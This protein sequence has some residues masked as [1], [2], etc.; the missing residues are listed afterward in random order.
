[1]KMKKDFN[2]NTSLVQKVPLSWMT[3]YF[4]IAFISCL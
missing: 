1:M 4:K 3:D 2:I